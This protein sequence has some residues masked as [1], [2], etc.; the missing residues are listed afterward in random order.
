MDK[1]ENIEE[2]TYN[3]KSVP[4]KTEKIKEVFRKIKLLQNQIEVLKGEGAP[5]AAVIREFNQLMMCLDESQVVLGKEKHEESKKSEAS[6][7]MYNVLLNFVQ[8]QKLL[9]S[10]ERNLLQARNLSQQT[11]MDHIFCHQ[12][13]KSE[14]RPSN[15]VRFYEKALKAL[16][17]I[18]NMQKEQLDPVKHIEFEFLEKTYLV[19]ML[20]H[21]GLDYANEKKY[22]EAYQV[23]LRV[24]T[25]LE[26]VLEFEQKNTLKGKRVQEEKEG[27]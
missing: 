23:V 10:L 27:L 7:Q 12:K 8:H 6:G 11:E 19:Q 3:N 20:F 22:C 5:T 13:L 1:I 9:T 16:K 17:S 26:S 4:L 14:L 24:Q 15:I 21:V 2:I 25:D 18:V